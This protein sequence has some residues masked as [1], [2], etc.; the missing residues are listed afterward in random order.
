MG[1]ITHLSVMSLT[2]DIT[3]SK[4]SIWSMSWHVHAQK[5]PANCNEPRAR[6]QGDRCRI[7]PNL[8]WCPGRIAY[9]KVVT[10][11][12]ESVRENKRQESWRFPAIMTGAFYD[13]KPE[14][15][16]QR[17]NPEFDQGSDRGRWRLARSIHWRHAWSQKVA[18]RVQV[19]HLGIVKI[20]FHAN[21][22][23]FRGI[24]LTTY[25]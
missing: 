19:K 6:L 4:S 7:C 2:K 8:R 14:L 5:A 18:D 15:I 23:W 22:C 20:L 25:N 13:G 21:L 10:A 16:N 11:T 12:W 3:S 24:D 1:H 17:A 9:H